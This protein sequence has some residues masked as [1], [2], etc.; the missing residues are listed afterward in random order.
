MHYA[1]PSLGP[2]DY[3]APRSSAEAEQNMTSPSTN[4][5]KGQKRHYVGDFHTVDSGL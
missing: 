4:I 3:K 1:E 5:M 2:T